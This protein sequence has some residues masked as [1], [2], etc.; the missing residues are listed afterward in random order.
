MPFPTTTVVPLR[1]AGRDEYWLQ[2]E[3]WSNPKCLGLG[4]LEPV[5]KERRQSSGG[6]LDI[7]LKDPETDDMYEV[8]VMLGAT[9]E[10][11]IIRTIEYWDIEKRRWPQRNHRAVLV[12]EEVT[13]RFFN[14][15]HLLSHSIPIIAI[16]ASLL[17]VDGRQALHFS[18]VL[19][20]Y[21]EVDDGTASE[22]VPATT[23]SWSQGAPWTLK[24]AEYLLSLVGE[25]LGPAKLNP[26]R[27]YLSI[28]GKN[29]YFSFHRRTKPKSLL[30]FRV[31]PYLRDE[32]EKLLAAAGLSFT[33]R[34]LG[35]AVPVDAEMIDTHR[36]EFSRLVDL[37]QQSWSLDAR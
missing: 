32:A 19:D 30:R 2:D 1:A 22:A 35:F 8:E 5:G 25:R 28:A 4:D 29:N 21:E 16:Q 12:A 31:E 11:H 6:R 14:V 34:P 10:T 7:L 37:V 36:V 26:T 20:T 3:I 15:I 23:E 24:A 17:E 18:K 33:R 27:N 13:S 9:D